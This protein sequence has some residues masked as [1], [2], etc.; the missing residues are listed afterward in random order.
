MKKFILLLIT[1]SLLFSTNLFA[2]ETAVTTV[3]TVTTEVEETQNEVAPVKDLAKEK[4]ASIKEATTPKE[5]LDDSWGYF[6][7]TASISPYTNGL[8]VRYLFDDTSTGDGQVVSARYDLQILKFLQFSLEANR[9]GDPSRLHS[10]Y[11][12]LKWM[13]VQPEISPVGLS[14]G[15]RKRLAWHG[16]NT[17]F[18]QGNDSDAK[19]EKLDK[20]LLFAA[21]SSHFMEGAIQTNLY[22]D[23]RK[24]T[25]GAK[26]GLSS[27]I[28]VFAEGYKNYTDNPRVESDF[29]GGFEFY[30]IN[31]TKAVL[32]YE[33]ESEKAAIDF[34][35]YY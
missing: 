17:E 6:D 15:S 3:T 20:S 23:A 26:I 34:T 28:F 10:A 13:L 35:V 22:V 16:D 19:N 33:A 9:S 24:A 14:I 27:R 32:A 2:Q 30:N 8:S 11:A 12:Y 4:I 5:K 1:S 7:P 25:V 18:D 31:N 29:V 21:A